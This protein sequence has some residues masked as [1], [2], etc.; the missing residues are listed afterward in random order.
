MLDLRKAAIATSLLSTALLSPI[1]VMAVVPDYSSNITP[2]VNYLKANQAAD[3][4]ITGFGGE[5]AWTVIGLVANGIDPH[6]VQNSGV[7]VVDFL[8][9]NAPGT[10]TGWE[11]DLL[12]VTAAGENP[13]TFG[14]H[15][16]V[17]QIESSV[18]AGQ[19]GS[20]T[21]INDDTFGILALISTGPSAN[22]QIIFESVDFVIANQ[23]SD[24]GWSY[25]VGNPSDPDSTAIAVQ[26]L[27]SVQSKGFSNSG[28]NSAV[29]DGVDYLTNSQQ[30]AGG[31]DAG[32][33]T[34]AG[35]TAWS[36]LAILGDDSAVTNGLNF[37]IGKQDVSGGI[38]GGF[39]ADTYT[40]A[41]SLIAFGQKAF[42]VGE[43][44]GTFE[45]PIPEPQPQPEPNQNDT[46][47][48]V[49]AANT[50]NSDQGKVLAATLP[51]TGIDATIP[52]A[53]IQSFPKPV[54]K[55]GVNKS[56]IL[57]LAALDLGLALW[58]LSGRVKKNI[59]N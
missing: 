54:S 30:V 51:N 21:G 35:S 7:S 39:G 56:F 31:W 47:G 49:L 14:G 8:Q 17:S 3:G 32:F 50:T 16:Y 23:N 13:F 44:D 29:N 20:A 57:S 46:E 24:G 25:A 34:N 45:Q 19:I 59:V 9:N 53:V 22:Q 18:S 40:S 58:I 37:I 36:V 28:L 6:T 48:R 2:L 27:Q 5:T 11:R 26:A 12:A 1:S 43:F 33:G 38:D 55:D 41:N 15:N 52:L 42:P 4:S 10:V